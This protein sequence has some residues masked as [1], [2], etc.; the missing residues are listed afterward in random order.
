MSTIK[1]KVRS[2]APNLTDSL[3]E[4]DKGH[5]AL[6]TYFLKLEEKVLSGETI[7]KEKD[8]NTEELKAH[9][10]VLGTGANEVKLGSVKKLRRYFA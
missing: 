5:Q 10:H 3:N 1:M 6:K 2:Y 4:M 7:A 8:Y 9:L